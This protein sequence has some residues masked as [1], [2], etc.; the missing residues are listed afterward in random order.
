M[1][2]LLGV[3]LAIGIGGVMILF[4]SSPLHAYLT[5]RGTDPTDV[6]AI[7]PGMDE[8]ELVGT[9]R[10]VG[11]LFTAPLTGEDAMAH[12]WK[13][14]RYIS[15][16]QG[17]DWSTVESGEDRQPFALDDGTGK[18]FVDPEGAAMNLEHETWE[19]G[20]G[21]NPSGKIRRYLEE[22]DSS[23]SAASEVVYNRKRRFLEGRLFPGGDVYVYGPIKAGPAEDTPKGVVRSYVGSDRDQSEEGNI[24]ESVAYGRVG[25]GTVFT[26][27]NTGEQGTQRTLLWQAAL[28][29][30]AGVVFVAIG[31]GIMFL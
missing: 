11:E 22:S 17:N 2:N 25:E 29:I 12:S 21:E 14:Q 16:P 3:V 18:I 28:F 26:V 10:P 31:V 19:V 7:D 9:A 6:T 27:S 1:V 30:G 4:G 24:E 8:A 20:K 13:V 15:G 5:V 23:H